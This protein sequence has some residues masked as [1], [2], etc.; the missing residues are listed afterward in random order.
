MIKIAKY[1]KFIREIEVC[2]DI[3]IDFVQNLN[4]NFSYKPTVFS[5]EDF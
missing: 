3:E 1:P 5:K 4:L 2:H